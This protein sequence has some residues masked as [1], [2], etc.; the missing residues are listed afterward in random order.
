MY[1]LISQLNREGVTII[2]I[3]HDIDAA[4]DYASH[5]L[6]IGNN[7]FFGTRDEYVQ[8]AA[9]SIFLARQEGGAAE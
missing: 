7:V 3:S 4:L 1:E 8:S 5:I 9:G 2:M 6:H